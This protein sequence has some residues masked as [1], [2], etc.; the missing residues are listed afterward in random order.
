MNTLISI[1]GIVAIGIPEM[2]IF[3][4]AA[5]LLGFS[6][7][8]YWSGRRS[9]VNLQSSIPFE[10]TG[11]SEEDESRL[12]FYE[13][14]ERHEKTQER[15]E[16]EISRM[17]VEEKSL[18]KELNHAREEIDLLESAPEKKLAPEP[19]PVPAS[20]SK[21]ISELVI[22]QQN[23][24]EYLSKEMTERLEKA[25]QE[26]NFL[27]DRI[28][29]IESQVVDPQTRNMQHEEIEQSYFRIT[30]EYDELKLRH[31]NL[32]E[33]N[34]KMLRLLADTE[35]KLRDSN[36]QKLQLTK[37]VV[38]LEELANDLQQVSGHHKKLEGQLKRISEI[39]NLL[40]RTTSEA[41]RY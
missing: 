29:K 39:E 15:L 25:Y 32:M 28:Q 12:S 14:L 9:A 13:Q 27:Q 17:K 24:N 30:K 18:L 31:L 22:A 23:L 35:E 8:F 2:V 20:P 3:F 5:I 37:K 4:M 40:T 10:P 26:F 41:K 34:Q 36:F 11:I 1:L 19:E 21:H 7:H 33:E 38:F 16:K 6:I